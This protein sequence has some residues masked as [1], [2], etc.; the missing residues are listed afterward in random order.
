MLKVDM[1]AFGPI[2]SNRV[3]YEKMVNYKYV[4]SKSD[5]PGITDLYSKLDR[6]KVGCYNVFSVMNENQLLKKLY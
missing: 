5:K 2:R 4:M 1:N 6:G 3:S